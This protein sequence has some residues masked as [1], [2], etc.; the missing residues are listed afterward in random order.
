MTPIEVLKRARELLRKPGGWAQ[1][2]LYKNRSNGTCSY[3]ALGAVREAAGAENGPGCKVFEDRR[4]KG[5]VGAVKALLDNLP[6]SDKYSEHPTAEPYWSIMTFND[7]I[8]DDA[9]DVLKVFDAAIADLEK[10]E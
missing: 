10:Q 6:E 8:A 4:R 2:Y 3:C 5:L 9:E 1:G 7:D